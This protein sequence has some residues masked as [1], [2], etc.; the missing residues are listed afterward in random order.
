[1]S[2]LN[3]Q[4]DVSSTC[5]SSYKCRSFTMIETVLAVA[6]ISVMFLAVMQTIGAAKANEFKITRQH[7]ALLLA[8]GLMCEILNQ[9]Y[10][11][12]DGAGVFGC[13]AGEA[14]GNR[15][16]YDDVDDYDG[17]LSSPPVYADGTAIGHETKYHRE[18]MIEW[19]DPYDLRVVS[20]SETGAKRIRVVVRFNDQ[21]VMELH[22]I[23]TKVLEDPYRSQK[24]SD[25]RQ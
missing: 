18:V 14:S 12:V 24:T 9:P 15:Q 23:R 1:M 19:V 7:G 6:L 16:H 4:N 17:W 13:E 21:P 5:R 25:L 20:S 8:Q 2:R 11:E 22:A 3:P 10:D